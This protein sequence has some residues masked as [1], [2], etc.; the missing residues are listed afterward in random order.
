[1]THSIWGIYSVYY[2]NMYP[3][4]IKA[5]IGLDTSV[6][7]QSKSGSLRKFSY[8]NSLA[9]ATGLARYAIMVKPSLVSEPA[10]AGTFTDE[11]MKLTSLMFCW[12]YNNISLI[13]QLNHYQEALDTVAGM[14]YP[15]QIPVLFLLSKSSV[16][17]FKSIGEDWAKMHQEL[18]GSS[19][20]G[21]RITL[22][23]EHCLHYTCSSMISAET[24]KFLN[25]KD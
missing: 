13:S 5:V 18:I 7:A 14:K 11:Q 19:G 20:Y 23:G 4:E 3:E 21:K 12:H 9:E 17:H 22:P 10:P 2:A 25:N 6:P 1:M 8:L 16:D 15:E 24:S